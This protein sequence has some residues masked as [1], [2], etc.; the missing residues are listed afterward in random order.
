MQC[1]NR[2]EVMPTI[3]ENNLQPVNLQTDQCVAIYIKNVTG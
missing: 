1:Y 2:S 3:H